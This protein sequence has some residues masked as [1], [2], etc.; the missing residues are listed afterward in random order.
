MA[1][2]R[3]GVGWRVEDTGVETGV[4]GGQESPL[5]KQGQ[6]AAPYRVPQAL[7]P[8]TTRPSDAVPAGMLTTGPIAAAACSDAGSPARKGGREGGSKGWAM[9]VWH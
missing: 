7:L 1:R 9:Q 2:A 4:G 8:E 3:K 5:G 6:V